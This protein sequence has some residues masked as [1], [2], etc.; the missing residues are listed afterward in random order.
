MLGSILGAGFVGYLFNLWG[1]NA[2]MSFSWVNH[3]VVGGF[4]LVLFLWQPIL[5]QLL[6]PTKVNGSMVLVGI[7]FVLIRA[8]NPAYPEGVMLAILLMNVFLTI[9][10][11]VIKETLTNVKK[12]GL[13]P[14]K[15][16]VMNRDSTDILSLC[17]LNGTGGFYFSFHSQFS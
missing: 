5:F 10:H 1:A 7:F 2:L 6:K 16:I 15:H 4:A 9:D 3:L 8:F 14:L 13:Q 11:Y 17:C 12:D